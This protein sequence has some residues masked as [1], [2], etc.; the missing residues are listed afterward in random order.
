MGAGNARLGQT[1][2]DHREKSYAVGTFGRDANS[3][4][5]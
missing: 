3:S 1:A 4:N 2:R 5:A